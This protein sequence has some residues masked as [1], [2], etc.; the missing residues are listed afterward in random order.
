MWIICTHLK[1]ALNPFICCMLFIQSLTGKPSVNNIQ[2]LPPGKL[3][4]LYNTMR[5]TFELCSVCSIRDTPDSWNQHLS[6]KLRSINKHKHLFDFPK[7]ASKHPRK[8]RSSRCGNNGGCLRKYEHGFLRC[9][10]S[11]KMLRFDWSIMAYICFFIRDMGLLWQSWISGL[12]GK[13]IDDAGT[14]DVFDTTLVGIRG[15]HSTPPDSLKNL[16]CVPQWSSDLLKTTNFS[17]SIF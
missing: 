14:E 15:L 2:F 12:I 5:F 3:S 17:F 9:F 7:A 13:M 16:L 10:N 4:W 6:V 8:L 1:I 11:Q